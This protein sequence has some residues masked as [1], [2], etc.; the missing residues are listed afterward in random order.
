[1]VVNHQLSWFNELGGT[2]F[3]DYTI[4]VV[5]LEKRYFIFKTHD[6][7]AHEAPPARHSGLTGDA[8]GHV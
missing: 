4:W 6:W 5:R 2:L 1:M 7:T 8:I 3:S